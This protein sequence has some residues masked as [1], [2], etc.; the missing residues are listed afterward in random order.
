MVVQELNA[1]HQDGLD[2]EVVD[3]PVGLREEGDVGQFEHLE[4]ADRQSVQSD[5][6]IHDDSLYLVYL[7]VLLAQYRIVFVEKH[8]VVLKQLYQERVF[9][10]VGD[11][12]G[13]FVGLLEDH[14]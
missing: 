8:Q 12:L 6:H 14:L 11:V 13:V 10:D 5:N 3:D 7:V 4:G 2:F 1:Q 9:S